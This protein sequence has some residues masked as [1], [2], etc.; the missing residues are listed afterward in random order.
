MSESPASPLG[1]RL[2]LAL[3]FVGSAALL[4]FMLSR[5]DLSGVAAR[6]DFAV[7]AQLAPVFLAYGAVSLWLEAL[8]LARATRAAGA[9]APLWD[10]ARIKAASYPLGLIHYT[11]GIAGL[12]YLIQKRS[13]LELQR[14]LGAVMLVSIVDLVVVLAFAAVGAGLLGTDAVPLRAGVVGIVIGGAVAGFALLRTERSLGPLDTL[15]ELDALQPLRAAPLRALV[16]LSLLRLAFI[17]AFIGLGGIVLAAFDVTP[18]A[19]A[20]AFGVAFASLVAVLPIAVSGVGTVQWAFDLAFARYAD[21]ESAFAASVA[22]SLGLV[23]LRGALGLVF[24]REYTREALAAARASK[25][26]PETAPA[27]GSAR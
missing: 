17:A 4:A 22:L 25:P 12:G 8:S 10:W 6:F 16:E 11:V 2:R 20:V 5:L 23:V 21:S 19:A 7:L 13:G 18:P 3:P 14:A 1:R 26:E 9:S 24:A 15:R 27:G